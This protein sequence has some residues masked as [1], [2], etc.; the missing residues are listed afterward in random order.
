MIKLRIGITLCLITTSVICYGQQLNVLTDTV[1]WNASELKDLQSDTTLTN[2][3][4]F[5]TYGDSKIVWTQNSEYGETVMTY[6]PDSTAGDWNASG[7]FSVYCS[8]NGK[9]RVFRFESHSDGNKV[10]VSFTNPDGSIRS[11]E[12]KLSEVGILNNQ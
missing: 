9:S 12:F 3:S 8:K 2:A 1:K 11:L 5:V 6:V 10:I 7:Y 4:K